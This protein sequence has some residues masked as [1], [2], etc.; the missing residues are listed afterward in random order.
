MTNAKEELMDALVSSNHTI[1]DVDWAHISYGAYCT[2]Q[3]DKIDIIGDGEAGMFRILKALQDTTYDSG[4]GTQYLG[5]NVV[6]KDGSWL[7]REEYDGSENWTYMK[8]P[9]RPQ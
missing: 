3:A 1:Q 8:T 5:G 7:C 9:E 6:F 4:Y 2:Q